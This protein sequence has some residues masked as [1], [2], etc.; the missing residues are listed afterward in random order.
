[1][2]RVHPGETPASFVCQGILELLISSYS[3]ASVLREHV[4]FKIIPMLNPDGVFLGNYRSNLMGVDLNRSWHI[5]TPW[6]HPTLRA[7]IDLLL[8]IEKNKV[9]L[10]YRL[11][12]SKELIYKTRILLGV[13]AGFCDRHSCTLYFK[14]VFYI[15][16]YVWGCLQARIFSISRPELLLADCFR[17]ERHIVFPKL[18]STV[19]DDYMPENT[20]FNADANKIGTARRYLC[21]VLSNHVNCYAFEVSIFGYRLKG[22]DITV[23]YTEDSCIL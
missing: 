22:S 4:V 6:A 1:M 19:A 12:H 13:S 17:Y 5:A 18:L 9:G 11:R 14:R 16:E 8:A 7:V 23:P 20:M 2:A 3:V 10:P 15:R 21:S